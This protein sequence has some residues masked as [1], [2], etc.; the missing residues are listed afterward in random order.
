M[1]KNIL[2]PEK[3][4]NYYLFPKRLL[5]FEINSAHIQ[6][7]LFVYQGRSVSIEKSEG[8]FLSDFSAQAIEGGIK[9]LA[10]SMKKFD[11]V[12]TSIPSSQVVFKELELPFVGR[13]KIT[14][15]VGFEVEQYLPFSYQEAV[16]DFIV[17][18][19]DTK[20]KKSKILVVAARK[21]DVTSMV[22]HFE[23]AKV[24]I[25]QMTVDLF[26]FYTVYKSVLYSPK[27]KVSEL[28]IDLGL[29]TATITY[30]NKGALEGIRVVPLGLAS[31]V[32]KISDSTG[33]GYYDVMQQLLQNSA[34]ESYRD[35][36]TSEL[37]VLV[38]QIR[39]S[40]KFFEKSSDSYQE[41]RHIF[42]YGLGS[43]LQGVEKSI[44]DKL[45]MVS[46]RLDMKNILES[47]SV[48]MKS[49]NEVELCH[50]MG[51]LTGLSVGR[52][53]ESNFLF[54][55]QE[56]GRSQ[57]F[58]IQFIVLCCITFGGLGLLYWDIH[59]KVSNLQSSY[60]SSKKELVKT[61][62]KS[63]NVKMKK[64]KSLSTIVSFAEDTLKKEKELWFLFSQ[65]SENGF[66]EYLQKL[67]TIDRKDLN[68]EL[69]KVQLGY[70]SVVLTGSVENF[71][72]LSVL[73]EEIALIPIFK[74]VDK[75]NSI[76][77]TMELKINRQDES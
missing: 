35:V 27:K 53:N 60:N 45:S 7:T 56:K 10:A 26:S 65:Q 44:Q 3:V 18:S 67:S 1:L 15:I 58:L 72:E 55:Q 32:Q 8:L 21:S 5:S 11:E 22:Q 71:D 51:L 31:I 69:T 64:S 24:K 29:D 36:V 74:L 28:F 54:N 57:L 49:E 38:G 73:Q 12:V 20:N 46:E 13:E 43:C 70:D 75:P 77:F 62:E 34:P 48:K 16:V 14:M 40:M 30:M 2:L 23:K 6:A 76:A 63:M 66:L 41:P 33:V 50:G 37:D 59:S 4:G 25:D 68:L 52:S 61:I 47:L 19:E 42:L 9:K 17:L 39:M